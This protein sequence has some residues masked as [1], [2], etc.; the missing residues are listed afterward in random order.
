MGATIT[1]IFIYFNHAPAQKR[2]VGYFLTRTM[3]EWRLS[4]AG[5]VRRRQ[6][7]TS[8]AGGKYPT[9]LFDFHN[10][11]TDFAHSKQKQRNLTKQNNARIILG[12]PFL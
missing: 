10:L 12:S 9:P 7:T 4:A 3:V 8:V 11:S 2:G 5:Y 1:L 6:D